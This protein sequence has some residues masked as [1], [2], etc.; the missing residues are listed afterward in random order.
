MLGSIYVRLGYVRL[1]CV[2]GHVRPSKLFG[3]LCEARECYA[4]LSWARYVGLGKVG[5]G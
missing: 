1:G 2:L 5:L 4:N 3:R